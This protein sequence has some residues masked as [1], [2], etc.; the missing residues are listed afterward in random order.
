MSLVSSL[1][2]RFA[3]EPRSASLAAII[4]SLV[5]P[6]LLLDLGCGDGTLA[7]RVTAARP[8]VRIV[9]ADTLARA[10]CAVPMARYD[11]QRLPFASSAFDAVLLVDV[12]HHSAR[13]LDLLAEAGRV[14][15]SMVVIKDHLADRMGARL[16][17]RFM[18]WMGN[19]R[20][21]VALPYSYWRARDWHCAFA[22]LRW[23][24]TAWRE[25]LGLYP[26]PLAPAFET[27]LHFLAVLHPPSLPRN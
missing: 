9:G 3:R 8:D 16:L 2:R 1:H 14:T 22:D 23:S 18:D 11:G 26:G 15:R 21:G 12:V 20:Q 6:G 17:L 25:H 5:P 7:R 4:A 27:G 19:A 10:S 13:P 24:V